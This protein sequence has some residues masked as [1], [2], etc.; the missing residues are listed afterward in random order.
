M[1]RKYSKRTKST[2]SK[3]Y[4]DYLFERA[5][6][7]EKGY[8]LHPVMSK[9]EFENEYERFKQAKK[10]GEIKSQ[11]FQELMRREKYITRKQ[12]KIFQQAEYEMSHKKVTLKQVQQF[13][14]DKISVLGTYINRT[15]VTGLYGGDYE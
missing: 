7:E 12:A 15:K 6:L 1:A 5:K 11:P 9:E 13:D 10:A 8:Y 4:K 14:S 2:Q 3:S